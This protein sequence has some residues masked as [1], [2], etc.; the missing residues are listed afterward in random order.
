MG[1][2][3]SRAPHRR[4][5]AGVTAG[6][7]CPDA[8]AF[9]RHRSDGVEA[10]LQPSG[11]VV[12]RIN[13]AVEW[14]GGAGEGTAL[15]KRP[16][17]LCV[18]PPCPRA[19]ITA[20]GHY[21]DAAA[22][23]L[24]RS[25][26]EETLLRPSSGLAVNKNVGT[27]RPV[28]WPGGAGEGA[29][30]CPRRSASVGKMMTH[31]RRKTGAARAEMQRW[32]NRVRGLLQAV[33]MRS[34]AADPATARD[35]APSATLDD[36]QQMV[37]LLANCSGS[38]G[39]RKKTGGGAALRAGCRHAREAMWRRKKLAAEAGRTARAFRTLDAGEAERQG[40][41]AC[42]GRAAAA[43]AEKQKQARGRASLREAARRRAALSYEASLREEVQTGLSLQRRARNAEAKAAQLA[44]HLRNLSV[45]TDADGSS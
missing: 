16:R 9:G 35:A 15:C 22:C 4:T 29:A 19:D 1:R 27:N 26:S 7:H 3:A 43:R 8:A 31:E 17:A 42:R 33:R 30:L 21:T 12:N 14:S 38:S 18:P 45:R 5:G 34:E 13:T 32:E 40:L 25:E 37:R 20:G 2:N 39:R 11:L 44:E 41:R 28:E 10:P 24:D 36:R 23:G 6:G